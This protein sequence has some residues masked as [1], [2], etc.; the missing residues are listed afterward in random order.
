MNPVR[1]G[2]LQELPDE[3]SN[4][5][6]AIAHG[7]LR[8]SPA[9]ADRLARAELKLATEADGAA[10]DGAAG[11][12]RVLRPLEFYEQFVTTISA[13]FQENSRETRTTLSDLIGGAIRLIPKEG[14]RELSVCCA[15]STTTFRLA[16]MSSASVDT[17][18]SAN[19]DDQAW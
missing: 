12:M 15:L 11:E 8:S 18:R 10:V 3:I 4:L 1:A 7:A 16:Q 19:A 9:L 14:T 2:R 13:R 17:L 5:V 6:N